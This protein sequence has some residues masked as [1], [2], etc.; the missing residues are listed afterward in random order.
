MDD[1]GLAELCRRE[2]PRLVGLL[3]LHVADRA[4]A[5]ELAQEALIALIRRGRAVGRPGPWLTRTAL[6]LGRS[7][8]RRRIA[9]RRAYRRHGPPDAR[10]AT[11]DSA[12]TIAVR[13]AVAGLPRRQREAVILRFYEQLS[14]AETAELMGCAEG[15]VK[16]LTHK[17]V[18]RLLTLTRRQDTTVL[19]PPEGRAVRWHELYVD[20]QRS[21][22]RNMWGVDESVAV[23]DADG[24]GRL[25][26]AS[27]SFE[28]PDVV[29]ERTEA[30]TMA[31]RHRPDFDAASQSSPFA[32]GEHHTFWS[33]VVD[34][35]AVD[36]V[37]EGIEF[38]VDI[39]NLEVEPMAHL[40]VVPGQRERIL[41]AMRE[42]AD[43]LT[44]RGVV[45][46]LVGRP[47]VAFSLPFGSWDDTRKTI[48]FSPDDGAPRGWEYGGSQLAWRMWALL[49]VEPV[50]EPATG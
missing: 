46:D 31:R 30:L 16:A 9:E 3:A 19:P 29:T 27:T 7:W 32:A 40:S 37:V 17:A 1:E 34:E 4:V 33:R 39:G 15:T 20:E 26:W 49:D 21:A 24:A 8:I 44:Y 6:N 25:M 45:P 23:V 22:A 14:V 35:Q 38:Q 28:H 13:R 43:A 50:D 12:D 11:S 42:H 36:A 47:S 41:A 10:A 18:D 2:Y 48:L 5:E